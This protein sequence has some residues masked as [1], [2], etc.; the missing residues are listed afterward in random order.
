[1]S[2]RSKN[3]DAIHA[4]CLFLIDLDIDAVLEF[5]YLTNHVDRPHN[6]GGIDEWIRNRECKSGL[7]K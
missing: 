4:L 3:H 1:M 6:H 7:A 2:V 5:L